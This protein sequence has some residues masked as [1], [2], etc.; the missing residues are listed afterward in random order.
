MSEV[1]LKNALAVHE[2]GTHSLFVNDYLRS[3]SGKALRIPKFPKL[4]LDCPIYYD[5]KNKTMPSPGDSS[6]TKNST[7][8]K[9]MV[10]YYLSTARKRTFKK[11]QEQLVKRTH[12]CV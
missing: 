11:P 9:T 6:K 7:A 4:T 2:K 8:K 3:Q 1:T 12:Y 5:H 10:L